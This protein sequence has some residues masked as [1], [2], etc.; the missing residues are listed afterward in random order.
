MG[1][2]G[3]EKLNH[4]V[5]ETQRKIIHRAWCVCVCVLQ[6]LVLGVDAWPSMVIAMPVVPT[7]REALRFWLKLGF[8]SFGG[9]TG[10]I[11]I[12]HTELVD[13]KKWIDEERFLH[14]LNYCM[15][16][17]GPEATQLAT[18]CGWRLHGT[19]GG[20]AAG[21]LFVLPAAVLLWALSWIYVAHGNVPAIAA[22][23][24]GLKP[25]VAAIVA[26]AVIKI[27]QRALK[28]AAHWAIAAAAFVAIYFFRVPFPVIVA[29]AAGIGLLGLAVRRDAA[30]E[31]LPSQ[32]EHRDAGAGTLRP[33][34][35]RA[36]KV[37]LV[38]L[39]LWW[40]PVA[41][42]AL[43]FGGD[44]VLVREGVFFS[45]A[46][47]I[48]FG[49]AYAVLPYV[50][51]EAVEHH[52]WLT[53]PQMLDGLGL[54]ETTPGPLIMV[55]QFVG[56][57]GGW[58]HATPLSPLAMATLGAAITTWTTF[59]PSFLFIFLGA[60]YLEAL[61]RVTKLN[62]A[63]T[64]VTAAVVG[65]VLNLAVWFALQ[66][67]FPV[68]TTPGLAAAVDWFAVIVALAAF[69]A[70]QRFKASVV[71]VVLASGALGLVWRWVA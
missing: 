53:A 41:G 34:L 30:A 46:A 37:L 18:Y 63:L 40:A 22:I 16:L 8:I 20:I 11:A 36:A 15:L 10:Q 70:L 3:D 17:P 6:G 44:S 66:V 43:L 60:P 19:W 5:T 12:M 38:S 51:Q 71:A 35:I 49:G 14:A 69:V 26:A 39:A 68:T 4:R 27:G 32:R 62:A 21:T 24:Y 13:R 57:V 9:P 45:K 59:V 65:V 47:L 25:A 29:M 55:L 61:R 58:S 50:A 1:L 31:A 2:D 42:A 28:G 64:A 48:T 67:F 54:A 33:P 7:F 23:F 52:A 56:F